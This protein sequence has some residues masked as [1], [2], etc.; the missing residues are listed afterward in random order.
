MRGHYIVVPKTRDPFLPG[1]VVAGVKR[2]RA[3]WRIGR[4]IRLEIRSH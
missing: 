1:L 3:M 2:R 4:S